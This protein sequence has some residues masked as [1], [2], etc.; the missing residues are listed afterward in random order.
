MKFTK[1]L[2]LVL[3]MLMLVCV[4]V[5]CD[6]GGEENPADDSGTEAP[7]TD[8]TVTVSMKVKDAKGEVAY[9]IES[10]KYTGDPISAAEIIE[11]YFYMEVETESVE[12]DE[13]GNLITI[14]SVESGE[15]TDADGK[16]KTVYW[17]YSIN[18]KDGTTAMYEYIVQDGDAII[19]YLR[20]AAQ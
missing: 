13:V 2:S 14:G 12:I 16:T 17:W 20:E 18:G 1:I 11:D 19:F 7:S 3:A 5:A 6:K 10:Y 4:L 15:I 8:V 9:D